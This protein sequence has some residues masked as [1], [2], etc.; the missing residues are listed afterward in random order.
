MWLPEREGVGG[1]SKMHE[2]ELE[3]QASSYGMNNHQDERY[4]KENIFI[5]M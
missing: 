4:S 1:I 5:G 2:G 3:I